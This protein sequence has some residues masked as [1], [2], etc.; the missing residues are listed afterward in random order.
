MTSISEKIIEDIIRQVQRQFK[1]SISKLKEKFT[2]QNIEESTL[3]LGKEELKDKH[4]NPGFSS[5]CSFLTSLNVSE[6]SIFQLAEII[7]KLDENQNLSLQDKVNTFISQLEEIK[8]HQSIILSTIHGMK[9]LEA[10]HV[11]LIFCDKK[12]LPKKEKFVNEWEEREKKNLFFT[13]ITRP[14]I[15]L[16][17]TTSSFAECSKFIEP[18]KLTTDL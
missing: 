13:A 4:C 11:F 9:G 15:G 3:K 5:L 10:D 8:S 12:I 1:G 7:N 16:Y 2:K 17:I 14:R 18:T 6:N